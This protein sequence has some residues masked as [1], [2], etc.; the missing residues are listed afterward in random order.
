MHRSRVAVRPRET[1]RFLPLSKFIALQ[2][3]LY[4]NPLADRWAGNRRSKV[5]QFRSGASRDPDALST[6]SVWGQ[7]FF[8]AGSI[9]EGG[10]AN[11]GAECPVISHK[12]RELRAW[13]Q[14]RVNRR[15]GRTHTFWHRCRF[16]AEC[17]HESQPVREAELTRC[18]EPRKSTV[19]SH[20]RDCRPRRERRA[21]PALSVRAEVRRQKRNPLVDGSRFAIE[22]A[23]E[24]FLTQVGLSREA[25]VGVL[26]GGLIGAITGFQLTRWWN[27]WRQGR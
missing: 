11:H 24:E 15:Q 18:E 8:W 4:R 6:G 5:G 25:A 23:I 26:L 13:A 22:R 7:F 3:D 17:R 20:G 21:A 9:R 16:A 1:N 27:R 2:R 12:P 14:V 10:R 19:R